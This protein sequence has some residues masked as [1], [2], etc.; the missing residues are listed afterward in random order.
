VS[1]LERE[2]ATTGSIFFLNIQLVNE[3]NKNSDL[4]IFLFLEGR[5]SALHFALSEM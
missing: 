1:S 4:C 2:I 3:M 5:K